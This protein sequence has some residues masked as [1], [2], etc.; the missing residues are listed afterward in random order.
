MSETAAIQRL[1]YNPQMDQLK[2]G[3]IGCGVLGQ[4]HAEI[5][6]R[7]PNVKLAGVCD[8]MVKKAEALGKQLGVPFFSDPT[9]LYASIDAASVCTPAISHYQVS[10]ELLNHNVHLLIEKPITTNVDDADKLLKIA[11]EKKLTLQTGHIE[12]FNGAVSK[13]KEIVKNPL[14][15]ECDRI[16]FFDP[17]IADVGVVLDLMIH[18]IDI[19]LYLVGSKV[20][21]V[22]AIGM[23]ILSKTEDFANCRIEFESGAVCNLTASRM[24]QKHRRKIRIFEE[25]RYISLDYFSQEA[26]TFAKDSAKFNETIYVPLDV[27]KTNSL[28]EEIKAFVK[29][30]LS[31]EKPLVSGEDARAALDVALQALQ[32]IH[33]ASK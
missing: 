1:C 22:E 4:R 14:F 12:R 24:A 21:K 17:R 5:Y 25:N 2:V 29:C 31:G 10:S 6:N 32:Q 11:K 20:K 13:V 33:S 16:G 26:L 23:K 19:V 9:E 7:L 18:D 3:V 27:R 15:I 28:E 8:V 30:V